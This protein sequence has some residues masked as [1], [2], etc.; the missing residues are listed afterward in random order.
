[1]LLTLSNGEMLKR[2][3]TWAGYEPFRTDCEIEMTDGV[4]IDA[5]ALPRLKAEYL[6]LLRKD[7]TAVCD[8]TDIT[9]DMGKITRLADGLGT[10]TLPEGCLNLSYVKL[11]NWTRPAYVESPRELKALLMCADNIYTSPRT[12]YPRAVMDSDGRTVWIHPVTSMSLE[13][14]IGIREPHEGTFVIRESALPSLFE[15]IQILLP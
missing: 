14:A 12:D 9:S 3:R 13:S 5:V 7:P 8:P 6:R 4:D 15:K 2:F 10:L 11:S 1:M